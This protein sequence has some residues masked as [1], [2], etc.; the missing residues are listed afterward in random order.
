MAAKSLSAK[1]YLGRKGGFL[2]IDVRT[3]QEWEEGHEKEAIH[4]P[5]DALEEK[6][7]QLPKKPIALICHSGAR[8]A[9]ACTLLC[10]AGFEAYNV[11]GGM[12][13]LLREK[14]KRG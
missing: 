12:N 11:E 14:T 5:L 10:S 4:I 13:A 1:E 7:G 3:A 9:F 2:L 8:S 6:I